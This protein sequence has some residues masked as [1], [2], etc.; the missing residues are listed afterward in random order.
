MSSRNNLVVIGLFATIRK[1]MLPQDSF[2]EFNDEESFGLRFPGAAYEF[3]LSAHLTGKNPTDRLDLWGVYLSLKLPLFV[4]GSGF[5]IIPTAS[6][7]Y[8]IQ[9]TGDSLF[10]SAPRIVTHETMIK[11]V[12]SYYDFFQKTYSMRDIILGRIISKYYNCFCSPFCEIEV[13]LPGMIHNPQTFRYAECSTEKIVFFDSIFN[14]NYTSVINAIE[15]VATAVYHSKYKD[16][17]KPDEITW[18][19][20]FDN[21]YETIFHKISM[22]PQM[23]K[24]GWFIFGKDICEGY[25]N[26]DFIWEHVVSKDEMK[27]V[28][29]EV[30]ASESSRAPEE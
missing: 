4:R 13:H 15:E 30:V 26:P 22:V 17:V 8:E 11:M 9:Y 19:N 14:E 27:S 3:S 20:F 12:L 1:L 7:E 18:V 28:W 23:A 16:I 21:G 5:L 29:H 24:E 25:V 10:T 6:D 2:V